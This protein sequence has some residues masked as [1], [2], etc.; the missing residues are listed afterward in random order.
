VSV[1]SQRSEWYLSPGID[2][3]PQFAHTWNVGQEGGEALQGGQVREEQ[4]RQGQEEGSFR[5]FV[6]ER[7]ESVMS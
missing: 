6:L 1:L 3:P 4:G 2:A 5:E 7:Q